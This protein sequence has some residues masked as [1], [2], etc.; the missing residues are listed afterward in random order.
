MM[1]LVLKQ[2]TGW[3]AAGWAFSEAMELLSDPAFKLFVWVC[4]NAERQ[5]GR[6]ERSACYD[7][8]AFAELVE[9]GVCVRGDD[10]AIE[11]ADRYWPYEKQQRPGAGP[12]EFVEGV[13]KLL[14][15]PACVGCRFTP[16]DEK[17]ARGLSERGVTLPQV[18][19][20]IWLGCMRKYT[21]LLN[22]AKAPA[23]PI[24]SLQYSAAVI[25]EVVSQPNTP[26][27]YWAYVH[28]QF[29]TLE[30]CWMASRV[31]G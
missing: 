16:A 29:R 31:A 2:S 18:E 4:L 20:E 25:D 6:L 15:V 17:L 10:G 24:A 19:R 27:S 9:R 30:Q 11:A 28:R 3:F 23:M 13:R 21:T 12:Q 14:A 26:E 7:P 22:H 8:A 5:T 1:R